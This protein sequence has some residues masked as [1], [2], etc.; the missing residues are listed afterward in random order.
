MANRRG[1][2]G[3]VPVQH[4]PSQ[5]SNT[6]KKLTASEIASMKVTSR[7]NV[8]KPNNKV[9]NV[10]RSELVKQRAPPMQKSAPRQAVKR[11]PKQGH[12]TASA[13]Q[14]LNEAPVRTPPIKARPVRQAEGFAPP[15]YV[16]LKKTANQIKQER[17][18]A[19]TVTTIDPKEY[20]KIKKARI[21]EMETA[22]PTVK[23]K[24]IESKQMKERGG[25]DDDKRYK[26]EFQEEELDSWEEI[27]PSKKTK[28]KKSANSDSQ[29]VK[30]SMA[31][32]GR[33]GV[34]ERIKV[35]DTDKDK[36]DVEDLDNI[37]ISKHSKDRM[38]VTVLS[39]LNK[40]INRN[41]TGN[42]R[43]ILLVGLSESSKDAVIDLL[44]DTELGTNGHIFDTMLE[45]N[46]TIEIP[47]TSMAVFSEQVPILPLDERDDES[48][49]EDGVRGRTRATKKL[50]DKNPKKST[51]KVVVAVGE[52][53]EELPF[54]IKGDYPS[55]RFIFLVKVSAHDRVDMK[56][57]HSN[58]APHT[59][60]ESFKK[61]FTDL[62]RAECL[63]IDRENTKQIYHVD[64]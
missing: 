51:R 54:D 11:P 6:P 18:A 42:K 38:P 32:M 26:Y 16:S 31:M 22:K 49:E 13:L 27:K 64:L 28:T 9:H 58:V 56:R 59:P 36:Y 10:K 3:N 21:K 2:R 57:M 35:K 8:V 45:E 19:T 15:K 39:N 29:C 47:E 5:P 61:K 33:K 43:D 63:I 23:A 41:V 37:S 24:I 53:Y 60:F 50:S 7:I 17:I 55:V 48:S 12:R 25:D 44:M 4:A 30:S 52:E 20:E 40:L 46:E 62:T 1:V 34:S 14:E